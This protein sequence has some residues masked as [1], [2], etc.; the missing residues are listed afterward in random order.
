MIKD[1]EAQKAR[2]KEKLNKTID[3]YYEEFAKHSDQSKFTIDDIEQIM[4]KQQKRMRE[5]MNESNSD[6]VSSIKIEA[7][8]NARSAEAPYGEPKK[9]KR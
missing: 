9:G 7:K 8:K 2:L 3:E 5:T 6:L 4:L 1:I